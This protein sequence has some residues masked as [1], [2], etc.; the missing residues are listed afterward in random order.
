MGG[1]AVIDVAEVDGRELTERLG[2][3][4]TEVAVH[5]LAAGERTELPGELERLLVTT[6]GT[7][8]LESDGSVDGQHLVRLPPGETASVRGDPSGT[9]LV[10]SVSADATGDARRVD[11]AD[12]PFEE[13]GSSAV[14]T[15]RLTVPLG[16]RGMKVNAR[17]LE[18]GQRVPYHTEGT[19]EELFVPLDGPASM[20][21]EDIEYETPVGTI[22][23]VAPEVP[24]SAINPGE[25]AA[26]W[27]MVGAPPTGDPDGWDP[28]SEILED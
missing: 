14:R 15:A 17:R 1:Y 12:R 23:R 16:C 24:R 20:R 11:L 10:V 4:H 7:C 21:I 9:L 19:Q 27:V 26:T 25:R 2:C 3:E 18:P 5:R 22:V 8:R 13:P 28:G 6:A